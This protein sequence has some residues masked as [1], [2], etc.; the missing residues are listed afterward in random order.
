M[1][2]TITRQ[3]LMELW[4][5]LP[6]LGNLTGFEL[7]YAIAR[8]KAKLR[9]EVEALTEALNPS[10]EYKDYEGK[11]LEV[12]RKYALKGEQGVPLTQDNQFVFGENLEAFHAAMA[13]L[14][15]EY[16]AAIADRQKLIDDYNAGLREQITVD[17]HKVNKTDIPQAATVGQMGVLY[18]LLED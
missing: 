4:S 18:Y 8:T 14:N 9:G 16:A 13:P 3:E 11:R 12:A 5:G 15:L 2:I 1:K 10:K 6:T 7:G 17:V